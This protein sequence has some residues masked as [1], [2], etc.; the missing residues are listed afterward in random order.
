MVVIDVSYIEVFF[1]VLIPESDGARS[2]IA[3]R[4]FATDARQLESHWVLELLSDY[5]RS[6]GK[7]GGNHYP[8]APT[9]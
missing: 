3:D 7:V 6:M 8:L 2:A 1:D 5:T 4:Q 9:V